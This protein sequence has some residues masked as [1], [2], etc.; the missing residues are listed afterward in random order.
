MAAP[1]SAASTAASAISCG[2]TGNAFDIEGVWIAP[3]TAQVMMTLRLMSLLSFLSIDLAGFSASRIVS[4]RR[5][6]RRQRR[7]PLVAPLRQRSDAFGGGLM[8][9]RRD[10]PVHIGALVHFGACGGRGQLPVEAG[11]A[12]AIIGDATGGVELDGLERSEKRPA[13]PKAVL[14][15]VI[16][17]FRRDIALADQP[18]RLRQQRALQAVQDKAVDLAMDGNGHLADLA[19]NLA[20]TADGL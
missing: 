9:P 12:G 11:V 10:H 6:V 20:R 15:G 5:L 13:Q 1:A 8:R 2:V 18:E 17:V 14:D 7:E 16:E 19:I 3:V 4:L